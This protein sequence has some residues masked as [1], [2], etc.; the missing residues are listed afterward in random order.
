MAPLTSNFFFFL[1]GRRPPGP[2]LNRPARARG[3]GGV[4]CRPVPGRVRA[5][6]DEIDACRRFPGKRRGFPRKPPNR[7]RRRS[8]VKRRWIPIPMNPMPGMGRRARADEGTVVVK[9]AEADRQNK[10]AAG[11]WNMSMIA[12]GEGCFFCLFRDR[13]QGGPTPGRGGRR[14]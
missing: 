5:A 13:W 2:E 12:P 11:V 3:P 4:S 9:G 14:I 6:S 1:A 7:N 10:Q 8:N